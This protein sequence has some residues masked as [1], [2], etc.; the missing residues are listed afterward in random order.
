MTLTAETL[1]PTFDYLQRFF[2]AH[3]RD[4]RLMMREVGGAL[5]GHGR[6]PY[7]GHN[8]AI[9][10]LRN[11]VLLPEDR[12][13]DLRIPEGFATPKEF[14]DTASGFSKML[15]SHAARVNELNGLNGG[16]WNSVFSYAYRVCTQTCDAINHALSLADISVEPPTLKRLVKILER[17]PA[18]SRTISK[19]NRWASRDTLEITDEYDVQNL[20]HGVLHLDFDDIRPEVW[21][22]NYAGTNTRTDFLLPAESILIEANIQ[23]MP[24]LKRQSPSN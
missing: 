19:K 7:E 10:Y 5:H 22:P 23:R 4:H 18:V 1:Q 3:H 9:G 13:N 2:D 6:E 12:F 14:L 24:K 11:A 17:L 21:C 16:H 15:D 20:L 8:E